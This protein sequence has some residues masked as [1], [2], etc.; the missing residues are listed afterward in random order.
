MA[1]L[2]QT[3]TTDNVAKLNQKKVILMQR[4]KVQKNY[5]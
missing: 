4:L 5:L 2:C 1:Y 3:I